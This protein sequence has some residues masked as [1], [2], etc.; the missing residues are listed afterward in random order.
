MR[1]DDLQ[2]QQSRTQDLLKNFQ[3]LRVIQSRFSSQEKSISLMRRLFSLQENTQNDLE[4]IVEFIQQT[5]EKYESLEM[6]LLQR[7]SKLTNHNTT[8]NVGRIDDDFHENMSNHSGSF[9]HMMRFQH[10]LSANRSLKE[11]ITNG[12]KA[13]GSYRFDLYHRTHSIQNKLFH[14]HSGM[15]AGTFKA[16]MYGQVQLFDKYTIS[17]ALVLGAYTSMKMAEANVEADIGTKQLGAGAF[18]NVEVGVASAEV[19]AVIKKDELS[20]KASVGAAVISGKV[21]F[22]FSVFGVDFKI[23]AEGELLSA[24]ANAG[25]STK[26]DGFS[27]EG[28]L[29]L[30]AG[31]GLKLDVDW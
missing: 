26:S 12:I 19:K 1:I 29:S 24:G 5:I 6:S 4:K 3:N 31:L 8:S 2:N 28:K 10:T 16:G 13:S 7:F 18:A 25:F 22:S 11:Y 14:F 15:Y 27:I 23:A 17:P 30:I 9:R 21:G 20:L